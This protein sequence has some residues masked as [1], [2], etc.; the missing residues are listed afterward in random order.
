MGLN[1][2]ESYEERL[3]CLNLWS[4]ELGGKKREDLMDVYKMSRGK[5]IIGLPD[6]FILEKN[7]GKRSR[8]N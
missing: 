3:R 6:W 4:L 5:S 2:R 8:T 7:K 1:M